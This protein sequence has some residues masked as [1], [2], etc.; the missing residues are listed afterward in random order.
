M[1]YYK[2]V[3]GIRPIPLLNQYLQPTDPPSG[4]DKKHLSL[5]ARVLE[6]R[7][8]QLKELTDL[9]LSTLWSYI[10]DEKKPTGKDIQRFLKKLPNKKPRERKQYISAVL[11]FLINNFHKSIDSTKT[12]QTRKES[13]GKVHFL[14]ECFDIAFTDHEEEKA[15]KEAEKKRKEQELAE[16]ERKKQNAKLRALY[17]RAKE[18]TNKETEVAKEAKNTESTT[19]T[20]QTKET[21][22]EA[23]NND[24]EMGSAFSKSS[25]P[26]GGPGMAAEDAIEILD[27][28]DEMEDATQ[29]A[30]SPP[31]AKSTAEP[32]VSESPMKPGA[33]KTSSAVPASEKPKA[34]ESQKVTSEKDTMTPQQ[35]EKEYKKSL[36][37]AEKKKKIQVIIS[38]TKPKLWKTVP[39]HSKSA[40]S[41]TIS[42]PQDVKPVGGGN[43]NLTF[44]SSLE[45]DRVVRNVTF[46]QGF[47]TTEEESSYMDGAALSDIH[48]RLQRWEVS[49]LVTVY[50]IQTEQI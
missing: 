24:S 1:S 48:A 5:F 15:A 20:A 30:K 12:Q 29:P 37:S 27:S 46:M 43:G 10:I 42:M 39:I 19:E 18:A 50:C 47:H 38:S 28:D 23:I 17:G 14:L 41:Q 32:A 36:A 26:Q 9:G 31:A 35:K 4:A 33:S 6:R 25:A 2:T 8:A 21:K 16:I 22:Q 45:E 7:N 3:H 49:Q 13:L 40:R 34:T 44:S 11:Y